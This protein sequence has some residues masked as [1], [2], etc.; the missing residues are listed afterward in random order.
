M[1][2]TFMMRMVQEF[3]IESYVAM[4]WRDL[5]S[6]LLD[7]VFMLYVCHKYHMS[8]IVKHHFWL[9]QAAHWL[10]FLWGYF[11]GGM[12]EKEDPLKLC[13]FASLKVGENDPS[14]VFIWLHGSW[15]HPTHSKWRFFFSKQ[16][17]Y[18]AD[19]PNYQTT[20]LKDYLDLMII[21]TLLPPKS[22]PQ[23]MGFVQANAMDLARLVWELNGIGWNMAGGQGSICHYTVYHQ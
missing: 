4:F 5:A 9:L 21:F 17:L 14:C 10:W 8:Y 1:T 16:I 13:L 22:Q 6:F 20:L 18:L 2:S 15:S 19:P 7:Q 3:N 23:P 12:E 11:L